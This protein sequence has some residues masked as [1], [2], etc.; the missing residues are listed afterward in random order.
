MSS[1]KPEN[2][3]KEVLDNSQASDWDSARGEW[4]LRSVYDEYGG[5][6]VCSHY[7]ITQHCVIYNSKTTKELTVGNQCLEVRLLHGMRDL[8]FVLFT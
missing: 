2:L 8:R 7:P 1:C 3:R 6:C 4:A 5:T